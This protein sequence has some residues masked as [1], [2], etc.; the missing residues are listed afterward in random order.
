[1]MKALKAQQASTS[2]FTSADGT[3]SL[4]RRLS[5]R[6]L[7]RHQRSESRFLVG[8]QASHCLSIAFA[9][10]PRLQP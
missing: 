1:M 9:A 10:P 3:L 8:R 5:G 4:G 7:R 6:R 2:G